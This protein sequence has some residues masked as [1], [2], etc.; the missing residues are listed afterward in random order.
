MSKL[1]PHSGVP[2]VV[3]KK[4]IFANVLTKKEEEER[5]PRVSFR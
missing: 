3:Q 5:I 2:L 1:Y 4:L